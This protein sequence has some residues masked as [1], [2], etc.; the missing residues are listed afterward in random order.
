MK[1][2]IV[3]SKFNEELMKGLIDN[4]IASLIDSGVSDKD[5]D[6]IRVP[7]AYEIP[8]AINFIQKVSLSATIDAKIPSV[9]RVYIALGVVIDGETN[10]AQMIIDSTGKSL[11]E[12]S[13]NHG[14]F[15]INEIVGAPSYEV[16]KARCIGQE[17]TRGWYAGKAAV[18]IAYE[19]KQFVKKNL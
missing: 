17:E 2:K 10:H 19:M 11:L 9:Q 8:Q 3:A 6:L 13:A 14:F 5:I 15:I 18:E 4:T 1:Y 12:I 16:A 7:G